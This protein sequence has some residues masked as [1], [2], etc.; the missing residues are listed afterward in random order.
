MVL[1]PGMAVGMSIVLHEQAEERQGSEG[2]SCPRCQH[3]NS[4]CAGWVTCAKCNGL[5]KI[6]P[7]EESIVSPQ[8]EQHAGTD[9]MP[10]EIY[11]FRKI[12][13][14]QVAARIN[15]R[16][17]LEEG[18][19]RDLP[20]SALPDISSQGS[21]SDQ[22]LSGNLHGPGLIHAQYARKPGR[23]IPDINVEPPTDAHALEM[24]S[25]QGSSRDGSPFMQGYPQVISRSGTQ[26]RT[27]SVS[28]TSNVANWGSPASSESAFSNHVYAYFHDDTSDNH[29]SPSN[30][31]FD[32]D[33]CLNLYVLPDRPPTSPQW[34]TSQDVFIS[35]PSP[36]SPTAPFSPFTHRSESYGSPYSINSMSPQGQRSPTDDEASSPTSSFAFDGREMALP[37]HLS[38]PPAAHRSSRSGDGLLLPPAPTALRRSHNRGSISSRGH[39]HTLSDA[40]S[41]AG[42]Y[43]NPTLVSPTGSHHTSQG[44]GGSDQFLG[45]DQGPGLIRV[46]PA[47]G[48]RPQRI[49]RRA[50]TPYERPKAH[51]NI[52]GAMPPDTPTYNRATGSNS[53]NRHIASHLGEQQSMCSKPG[54]GQLFNN[55]DDRQR[56]EM[57]DKK[58]VATYTPESTAS[59]PGIEPLLGCGLSIPRISV[60]SPTNPHS[61]AMQWDQGS[62]HE[63]SPFM[64][65]YHSASGPQEIPIF[66]TLSDT[67]SGLPAS[68][69]GIG[70]GSLASSESCFSNPSSPA[71]QDDDFHGTSDH[72]GDKRKSPSNELFNLD[73]YLNLSALP[74]V[75]LMSPRRMTSQDVFISGPDPSS[76]AVPLSSFT[77]HSASYDPPYPMYNMSLQGQRSPT[78]DEASSP[79]PSFAFNGREMTLPPH[80]SQHLAAHRSSRSE[81]GLLLPT[82]STALRR[83]HIRGSISPKGRRYTSSD[84]KSMAGHD[85]N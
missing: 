7:E 74:D 58:H 68:P 51:S 83:S 49:Q 72:D 27:F 19:P 2:Y 1:Q 82:P 79:T 21:G 47:P 5:F 9:S 56:H 17:S 33:E 14:F 16:E 77:H 25:N 13:I 50:T 43:F 31:V 66:D 67:F 60:E 38:Q 76:A 22:I 10:D 73:E 69:G 12:S 45:G 40:E 54:C 23:S 80:P 29:I 39:R 78:H 32:S 20:T 71:N 62:Y 11:L 28:P 85:F 55:D 63:A 37:T 81:D 84:A 61:Q 8:T 6:S 34:S 44:S 64:Q 18:E 36:S 30:E 41:M 24:Q 52:L 53:R 4:R 15:D 65:G 3:I 70:K 42:H 48:S 26:S 75:S 46:R 57:R 35:V 59:R